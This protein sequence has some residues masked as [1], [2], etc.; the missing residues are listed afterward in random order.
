MHVNIIIGGDGTRLRDK[1]A[2]S[3]ICF[4]L[5]FCELTRTVVLRTPKHMF[6][7][8][9]KQIFIMLLSQIC[10]LAYVWLPT[11]LMYFRWCYYGD[12]DH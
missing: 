11:A 7:F 12:K 4:L 1:S 2:L 9:D 5:M 8:M 3:N 6:Q 10:I